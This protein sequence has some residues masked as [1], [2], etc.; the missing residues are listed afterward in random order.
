MF[1]HFTWGIPLQDVL[2]NVKVL[3]CHR[4]KVCAFAVLNR[5]TRITTSH[6]RR[7]LDDG[8]NRSSV[9]VAAKLPEAQVHELLMHLVPT[10]GERRPK[11][12]QQGDSGRKGSD[13]C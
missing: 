1:R 12:A 10:F 13:T 4:L 9:E 5:G 6:R 11:S 8:A 3:V 7:P 2:S